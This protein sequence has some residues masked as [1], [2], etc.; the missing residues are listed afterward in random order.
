M[1]IEHAHICLQ[2]DEIFD[3]LKAIRDRATGCPRCGN[4]AAWPLEKWI[5]LRAGADR[6]P[7]ADSAN[8]IATM[9]ITHGNPPQEVTHA[10]Q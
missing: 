5:G 4:T 9:V 7:Y 1:R 8:F 3:R 2:C 10:D 6:H